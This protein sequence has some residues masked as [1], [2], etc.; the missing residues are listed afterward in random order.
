LER[1]SAPR[2]RRAVHPIHKIFAD[3]TATEWVETPFL[4]AMPAIRDVLSAFRC[5]VTIARLM[6]LTPGSRIKPHSDLDLSVDQGHARLHVPIT[7]G[8][9]VEFKLNG[10]RVDMEPGSVWYLRLSDTHEV[11]NRGER[12][13]VHLV[14]DAKVNDW[15]LDRL[16]EGAEAMPD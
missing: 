2:H 6:R 10:S 9:D 15:L 16:R 12:D 14:F 13:R 4:A 3:P 11:V 8:P 7:T 5:P 1:A